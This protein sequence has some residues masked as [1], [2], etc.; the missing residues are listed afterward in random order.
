MATARQAFQAQLKARLY[1]DRVVGHAFKRLCQAGCDAP[2]LE[3]QILALPLFSWEGPK[4]QRPKKLYTSK[5]MK[6][7]KGI[8]EKLESASSDLKT[9]PHLRLI[10]M[11]VEDWTVPVEDLPLVPA[12]I[13]DGLRECMKS[14]FF[15]GLRGARDVATARRV[16]WLIE[17]VKRRTK[18]PHFPEMATLFSAAYGR[19]ISEADLK[20]FVH[21][22][23]RHSRQ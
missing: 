10:T 18:R 5:T 8:I 4:K 1:G 22:N 16:P 7:L 20:M 2:W 13:A 11:C 21:R 12:G 15:A 19:T 3:K 14:E 9:I 6:L 17:E 23:R